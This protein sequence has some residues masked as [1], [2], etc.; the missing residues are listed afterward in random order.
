VAEVGE[1]LMLKSFTTEDSVIDWVQEVH[2]T[3]VT[4]AVFPK[5][6]AVSEGVT[7]AVGVKITVAVAVAPEF[8]VPMVQLTILDVA[9]PQLP[10]LTVADVNEAPEEGKTSLKM[11][12]LA[13][14][15][16]LVMV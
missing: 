15:P 10:A 9:L 16:V 4:D 1:T 6:S 11:M 14:S 8:R 13:R 12:L 5:V 3:T 7:E 2:P